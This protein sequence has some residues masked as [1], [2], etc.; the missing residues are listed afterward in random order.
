ML[1]PIF[2]AISLNWAISY[3]YLQYL[4]EEETDGYH[5]FKLIEKQASVASKIFKEYCLKIVIL[6][7]NIQSVI[8]IRKVA[9][10]GISENKLVVQG[11]NKA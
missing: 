8:D 11:I 3:I 9:I 5:A 7:L 1:Q 4:K 6:I 2:C 10:G